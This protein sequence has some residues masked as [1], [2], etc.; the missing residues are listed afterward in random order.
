MT[1]L[2]NP[3]CKVPYVHLLSKPQSPDA[4]SL[5]AAAARLCRRPDSIARLLDNPIARAEEEKLV[6]AVLQ[7]GHW[8]CLR[9]AVFVFGVEGVSR[10]ESHQHVRHTAGHSFE[11]QS[12]HFICEKEGAQLEHVALNH[13]DKVREK[14][15]PRAVEDI[16]Q[17][18]EHLI[19]LSKALYDEMVISGLP[20]HEARQVLPNAAETRFIWTANLEAVLNFVSRRACRVNTAEILEVAT[21]VRQIVKRE[22]PM[23]E[24]YLGPT[25]YSRGVCYEGKNRYQAECRK[26]WSTCVLWDDKFPRVT[27]YVSARGWWESGDFGGPGVGSPEEPRP[28]EE[29]KGRA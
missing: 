23:L 28:Y 16:Q 4:I 29:W 9:H 24:P 26:P 18:Y 15:G 6:K 7:A 5:I 2:N 11:Q 1:L 19:Q 25:C 10:S 13:L 22:V 14:S 21:Q 27:T 8:S 3:H 12:Q 20:N 17:S